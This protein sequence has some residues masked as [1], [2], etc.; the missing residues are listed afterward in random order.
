ML[1][2]VHL[3]SAHPAS[4]NR[5]LHKECR[6][7][8]QAGYEVR[9]CAP[10]ER[11][12]VVDG[13]QIVAMPKEDRRLRRVTRGTARV[14][15]DAWR[16][17]ADLFHFH[18]PELIPVGLLLRARGKPVVYDV[19]EDVP[20]DILSRY[21]LEP[22]LRRILSWLF[23]RLEAFAAK[24]FSAVIAATPAIG[25]RFEQL[26]P[27]TEVINNYPWKNEFSSIPAVPWEERS[28]SVGYIG[29]CTRVRGAVEMVKAMDFVDP[30]LQACLELAGRF[31]PPGLQSQLATLP[32]WRC[33]E[34]R[35]HLSRK[36]V[37]RLL[38]RVR[39]G[40]VVLHPEPTYVRSQPTKMFEYMAAGI[41]VIAS[42]FPFWRSL[43]EKAECG[44]LVDPLD[45]QDIGRAI[46]DMLRQSSNA[47]E[48]GQCGREAV[49]QLF[50]WESEVSK[51]LDLYSRLLEGN[52]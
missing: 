8:A 11:D 52:A 44:I 2:I 41:P 45:P 15:R 51:L 49:V 14:C 22:S 12:E 31:G 5:I 21:Y 19:H 24:R 9:L 16:E 7:I 40:L 17:D 6:S 39:A 1:K 28:N 48:I 46:Q 27:N 20:K 50:N 25:K 42:D 32:G 37:G 33:V 47:E 43:I 3:T 13:V 10:H 38:K 23:A 26:N 4:D 36:G 18:D 29:A 34:F 30:D 35:G